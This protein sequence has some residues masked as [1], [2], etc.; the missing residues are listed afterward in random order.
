MPRS[1]RLPFT[2]A[3]LSAAALAVLLLPAPLRAQ[4]EGELKRQ[5]RLVQEE[6]DREQKLRDRE[7]ERDAAFFAS[8]NERLKRLQ[9]ERAS[10]AAQT[11]SLAAELRRLEGAR[12]KQLSTARWYAKR[13]DDHDKFLAGYCDSLAAL[14]EADFPFAKEER[15][16]SVAALK[17]QLLAGSVSPEEGTDRLWSLLMSVLKTGNGSENWSGT[18]ATPSGEISG[19]YLRL[20]AVLLAFVSDDGREIHLMSR[21]G[22][23]WSWRPVDGESEVRGA[24]RDALK[25]S[26]GKKAPGLVLLPVRADAVERRSAQGGAR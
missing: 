22:E 2:A 4:D 7:Q 1:E 23:E 8:A 20:G 13:H 19:K 11:D 9:G 25:V 26:E 24:L 17:E 5:I 6:I 12:A 15:L 21:E 16:R 14:V 18:L 3:L 10:V